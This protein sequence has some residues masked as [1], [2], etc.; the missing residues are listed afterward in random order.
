MVDD[1]VASEP[2]LPG[3]APPADLEIKKTLLGRAIFQFQSYLFEPLLQKYFATKEYLD[4]LA[5][6]KKECS[7]RMN[8]AMARCLMLAF[9][10][11]CYVGGIQFDV[12]V[13]GTKFF[14][15]PAIV[16]VL[17]LL[18]AFALL[19]S[20]LTFLDHM[21][22]DRLLDTLIRSQLQIDSPVY[23]YAHRN[24]FGIWH[25]VLTIR[26]IGYASPATH[27]AIT[28]IS[29]GYIVIHGMAFLT[30]TAG[31]IAYAFYFV[32]VEDHTISPLFET[33]SWVGAIVGA[34]SIFLLVATILVR[35]EF[36]ISREVAAAMEQ[37]RASQL[38]EGN[39][40]D[41]QNGTPITR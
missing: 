19:G 34:F 37:Q 35:F 25:D 9:L 38:A 2:Q 24:S 20:A 12:A 13:F 41:T 7:A 27:L 31:T 14:Q 15:F 29:L 30:F 5:V 33:M 16:E 18:T 10:L 6:E 21:I 4:G 11:A 28:G 23:A 39:D 32:V 36:K 17:T 22:V 40:T 8:S 1:D 3:I 26:K